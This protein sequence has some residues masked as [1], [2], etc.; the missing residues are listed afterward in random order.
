MKIRIAPLAAA[1]LAALA[2][3]NAWLVTVMIDGIAM[4]NP[5]PS[6]R[7]EWASKL[8]AAT[9]GLPRANPIEAYRQTLARPIFFK[10]REPWVAPPPA[11]PPTV[12]VP[13]PVVTDP[14]LVLGGVV[15][16]RDVRRAYLFSRADPRGTWVSEG[17]SFMGWK[18]QSIT[19]T[20]TKLQQHNR[21]I[22]LQLY[23]ERK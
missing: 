18:L 20:G 1:S 17:E 13:P 4:T 23:A 5:S 22:E 19:N 2:G 9:E 8:A 11:P 7:T 3:V 6:S 15:I 21:V 12:V 16:S 14:G 10:S